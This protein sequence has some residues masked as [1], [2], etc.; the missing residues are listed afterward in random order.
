MVGVHHKQTHEAVIRVVFHGSDA[1]H[2]HIALP[3]QPYPLIRRVGINRDVPN[4]RSKIL[5][6]CQLPDEVQVRLL[7]GSDLQ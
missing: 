7:K 3:G 4:A 1:S 6:T 2:G 5:L